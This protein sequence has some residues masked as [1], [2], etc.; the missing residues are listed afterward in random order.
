MTRVAGIDIGTNSVLLL[1]AEQA[2]DGTGPLRPIV[3]RATITRLGKGVDRTRALDPAAVDRTLACLADY[4]ELLRAAG[5]SRVDAV[6]TSAMRDAQ[7]GDAFIAR[8]HALLGVAPRVISGAEEA[9]L[10]FSGALSGLPITAGAVTVFDVGGGSTEVIAGTVNGADHRIDHAI[11]VDIGSVRLT[12]RHVHTDPP[13]AAELACV[14]ADAAGEL[15]RARWGPPSTTLIGVAGTLTTLA[16]VALGVEPYDAS[17]VHGARLTAD[18]I[19]RTIAHLASLPAAERRQIPG[20]DPGRADVIIAGGL[21]VEAA[22]AAA[23]GARATA[24][25]IVSDRGVRWG[26]VSEL[27]RAS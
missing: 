11:S 2:E 6:G 16:S 7:G 25:L 8:A 12:E 13:L 15:A 14:R 9:R 19:Q 18:Q 27:S 5:A 22:L 17:R 21:I 23:F 24:E 20:L 3:E 26:L 10:T 4:G 1:V